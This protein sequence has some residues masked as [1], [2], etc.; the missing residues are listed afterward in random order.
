[1]IKGLPVEL[2]K[3]IKQDFEL[4]M[5]LAAYCKI[6]DSDNIVKVLQ[7]EYE[8]GLAVLVLQLALKKEKAD[9]PI[10]EIS[11]DNPKKDKILLLYKLLLNKA[12]NDAIVDPR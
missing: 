2:K 7:K 12:V 11:K 9:I 5:K 4:V 8:P 6:L 1:M 10:D 3:E